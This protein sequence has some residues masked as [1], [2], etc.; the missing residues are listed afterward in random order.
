MIEIDVSEYCDVPFLEKGRSI[1]GWDCWG[2]AYIIYKNRLGIE[3]PLYTDRYKNTEDEKE[4]GRLIGK[5]KLMWEEVDNPEPYDLVNLRLKNQPMHVGVCIGNG[6]FLHCMENVG[7]TV[8]KLKS[9]TWRDRII[10]FYRY[11]K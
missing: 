2:P 3:L 5:E 9:L 8:E 7:T 1:E 11:S 6:K 10:G 4:L